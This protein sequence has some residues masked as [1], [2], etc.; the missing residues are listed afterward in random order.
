MVYNVESELK[1]A[2]YAEFPWTVA[3]FE[4]SSSRNNPALTHV[5]GGTLIHPKFVVTTAHTLESTRQYVAR[6]GEWD[7]KSN[8]EAFPTQDI[9]IEEHI[10]HPSYREGSMLEN[11][12]GLA[13]LKEN[14]IYSEHIRPLC[15]PNAQD[16]FEDQ[17]CITTGWGLDIRTRKLPAV[18]KRMELDVISRS[19][20]QDSYWLLDIPYRLHRSVMCAEATD[21]QNTCV[22]DGGS[23]L[24]CQRSDGSY[25]L[26][27][28]AS[29][30]RDCEDGEGPG[31]FVNVPKFACWINDTIANYEET[32]EVSSDEDTREIIKTYVFGNERLMILGPRK[33]FKTNMV[34]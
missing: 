7:M 1:Y 17:R 15:L 27:G 9:E 3:I 31:I 26:A 16:V 8:S 20:C 13:V 14:V 25:V 23:P 32:R 10:K 18:M 30:G 5:G 11:D 4:K 24:A 28:V 33:M 19:E 12:I 34:Q 22:K 21:D 2:K 29:M 6:F